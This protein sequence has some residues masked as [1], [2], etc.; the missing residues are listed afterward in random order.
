MRVTRGATGG[1]ANVGP[2]KREV[3]TTALTNVRTRT[4]HEET[5]GGLGGSDGPEAGVASSH[6]HRKN[7]ISWRSHS[8]VLP[9]CSLEVSN[10]SSRVAFFGRRVR[11]CSRCR[12]VRRLI[13]IARRRWVPGQL[14]RR[15]LDDR[16]KVQDRREASD[17][18]VVHGRRGER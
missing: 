16:R 15:K 14:Q 12:R 9:I 10:A 5:H 17:R 7:R 11:L 8:G 4:M 3:K 6:A 13:V 2:T 1:S 18:W